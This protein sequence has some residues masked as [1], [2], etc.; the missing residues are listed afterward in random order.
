MPNA[1]SKLQRWLDVVSFL[2]GRRL[3]VAT[4]ELWR[5]VPAYAR[6]VDGTEK[7]KQTVR[8]MFERDKDEL[9]TLGIP[10]E[11]VEYTINYGRE[12]I[13]GYRLERKDFHLPYLELLR[14]ADEGG[15]RPAAEGGG[16]P[17]AHGAAADRRSPA[18][19][20]PASTRRFELTE[21]EAGAALGG[22]RELSAVPGFPLARAARSAFRKLAF[23]LEPDVV[24]ET[25]VVYAKDPEAEAASEA[26]ARLSDALQRRK[27][28]TFTYR[29][30]STDA[31]ESRAVHA[32]GLL[33]QHGRWYL[34]AYDTA[35]DGV[36]MFRVG[37]MSDVGFNTRAPGTPDYDV[38]ADFR[39]AD[40]AGRNAW[41]LGAGEQPGIEARVRFRFPRSLWADR[42]GHGTLVEEEDDG[43]QRRAFTVHRRDPFLRW[44]LSL[45]GDAHVEAPDDLRAEF[46]ALAAR[47]A[48]LHEG[49]PSDV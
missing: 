26:L 8:R 25:P 28:A 27:T 24:T 30:I 41:E 15:D 31:E 13:S 7:E 14:E 48:G 19:A 3:P 42:N 6:G 21:G 4:E 9:R 44:V 33:F 2:A 39:L 16:R 35:R 11:T 18:S 46:H 49:D 37:R 32:Y 47:I 45:A 34:V 12:Q 17:G 23:D 38:P 10:I 43:A 36:R 29:A 20:R 1:P 40:F 22:L 5:N